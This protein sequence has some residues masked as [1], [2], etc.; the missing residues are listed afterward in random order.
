MPSSSF[1]T[2]SDGTP[3]IVEVTGATVT[4]D[5]Y[6]MALLRGEHEAGEDARESARTVGTDGTSPKSQSPEHGSGLRDTKRRLPNIYNDK[7]ADAIV[8]KF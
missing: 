5:Q 1:R 8:N 7:Q 2:T 3:R 6:A 4:V